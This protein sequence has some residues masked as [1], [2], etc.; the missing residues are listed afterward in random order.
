[1]IKKAWRVVCN[2]YYKTQDGYDYMTNNADGEIYED[3]TIAVRACND[4]RRANKR[5]DVEFFI[6][7]VEV[8]A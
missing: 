6:Q 2:E 3:R 1:M 7:E 8:E 4:Y 5:A